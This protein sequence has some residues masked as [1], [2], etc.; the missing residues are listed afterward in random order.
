MFLTETRTSGGWAPVSAKAEPGMFFSQKAGWKGESDGASST[1]QLRKG[2]LGQGAP[3][4]ALM[5]QD[6]LCAAE[7]CFILSGYSMPFA[8]EKRSEDVLIYL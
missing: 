5:G 7:E 6:R 8:K 3:S 2:S 1:L 4:S